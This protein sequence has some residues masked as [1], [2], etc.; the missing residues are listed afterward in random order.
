MERRQW[1]VL[2]QG[3]DDDQLYLLPLGHNGLDVN[4]HPVSRAQILP[5]FRQSRQ[6]GA[7]LNEH[8]VVLDAAHHAHHG[9]PHG[10]VL[11]VLLPGAQQ[12]LVGE[13]DPA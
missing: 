9:F 12:L 13:I 1:H 5:V 7:E 10:K 4:A 2:G 6:I 3:A 11:G 8:P